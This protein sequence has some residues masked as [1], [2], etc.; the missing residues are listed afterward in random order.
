MR[1]ALETRVRKLEALHRPAGGVFFALWGRDE[2]ELAAERA[3]LDEAG[4][5]PDP[6]LLVCAVW[7]YEDHPMPAPRWIT[8]G[9][10]TPIEEDAFVEEMQRRGLFEK[11]EGEPV[12]RQTDARL[13]RM[14]DEELTRAILVESAVV[15]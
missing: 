11:I 13:A 4:A 15:G 12:R 1:A 5:L 7:P 2:H 6:A 3:R 10:M 8:A 14:T 9:G